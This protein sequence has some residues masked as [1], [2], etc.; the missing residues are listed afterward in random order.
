MAEFLGSH[1]APITLPS[2]VGF[3]PSA[4]R[5]GRPIR[6]PGIHMNGGRIRHVPFKNDFDCPNDTRFVPLK[7][8][9]A[10]RSSGKRKLSNVHPTCRL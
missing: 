5:F 4:S 3:N 7:S 2:R 1:F 10:I 8:E 6:N 9:V